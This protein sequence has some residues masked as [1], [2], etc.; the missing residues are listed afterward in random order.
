MAIK[1]TNNGII[2]GAVIKSAEVSQSIDAFTGTIAYDIQ[3]SGS[4]N[5]T[6]ST[7]LSGS[8]FLPDNTHIGIGTTPSPTAGVKLVLKANDS[9]NDPTILLEG[10]STSDSATVGFKN[11]DVRWNLGLSG[12]SNDSFVLQNQTTNKFPVLI[13]KLSND[14]SIALRNDTGDALFQKVG[15]N[16]PYG[17][18]PVSIPHTLLISGSATASDGFYGDLIGTSS[19][20]DKTKV[21]NMIS[22]ATMPVLVSPGAVGNNYENV[23]ADPTY[24]NFNNLTKILETTASY[25]NESLIASSSITASYALT[26]E[27]SDPL[28]Y[29]ATSFI[30]SSVKVS[31]SV[32]L[33]NFDGESV[34]ATD[35]SASSVLANTYFSGSSYTASN[36]TQKITIGPNNIAYDFDG[37]TFI[38]NRNVG[39]SATLNIGVGGIGGTTSSA[40]IVNNHNEISIGSSTPAFSYPLGYTAAEIH[41]YAQMQNNH[42]NSASLLAL[43]GANGSD[44]IVYLGGNEIYGG[45]ILYHGGGGTSQIP[46]SFANGKTSLYRSSASVPSPVMDFPTDNTHI[47]ARL[48]N[49][50]DSSVTELDYFGMGPSGN[51]KPYR[52]TYMLTG[53]LTSGFGNSVSLGQIPATQSGT[54]LIRYTVGK[55]NN[56]SPTDV[57]SIKEI[58]QTF[59]NDQFNGTPDALSLGTAPGPT[60]VAEGQYGSG[61]TTISITTGASYFQFN[62]NGNVGEN[63]NLNGFVELTFFPNSI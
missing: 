25:A 59:Y 12:G 10:F 13:D 58:V 53:N 2:S 30:S 20:T 3:Q 63:M 14:N 16:W 42:Q 56:Q 47:M 48:Q 52:R 24:L 45:G 23:M 60:I 55:S 9:T 26:A 31:S 5:Q 62:A 34:I 57:G 22:N 15:I 38:Q 21:S 4:F 41:S 27:S 51:I 43:K 46:S 11:P 54:Y 61:N 50:I 33:G 44:G 35:V 6:G 49:D 29:D 7:I 32:F 39:S 28:W 18:M 36:A 17:E 8:V 1:L 40:L 19:V 37:G